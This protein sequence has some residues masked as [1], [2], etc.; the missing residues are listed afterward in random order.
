MNC[1]FSFKQVK[2]SD[3]LIAQTEPKVVS[4]IE[5]FASKA[6]DTH[7]T[8]SKV[9]HNSYMVRCTLKGGDGFNLHVEATE[10]NLT[11][12]VDLMVHKLEKQLK[13]HKE[14][15]KDHKHSKRDTHLRLVEKLPP[16]E[17]SWDEV[18]IDAADLIKFEESTRRRVVGSR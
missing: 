1:W 10:D 13:R 3:E 12:A 6:I 9:G 8:F 16:Q 2:H 5:K 15:I 4:K 18:E 11:N 14:K 17:I 7:V